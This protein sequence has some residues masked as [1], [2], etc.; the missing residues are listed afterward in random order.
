MEGDESPDPLLGA[1]VFVPY[2][3]GV[4]SGVVASVLGGGG[5]KWVEHQGEKK[6]FR[7]QRHLLHASHASAPTR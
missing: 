3:K 4:Y 2:T 5:G 6:M 7:D 1:Q